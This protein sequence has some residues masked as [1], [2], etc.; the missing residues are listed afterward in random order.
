MTKEEP[1]ITREIL[2][3]INMP[4]EIKQQLIKDLF[5]Q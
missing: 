3:C 5:N 4:D 2:D 1:K